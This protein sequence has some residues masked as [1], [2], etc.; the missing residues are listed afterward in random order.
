[1][2]KLNTLIAVLIFVSASTALAKT[3]THREVE[4]LSTRL[5]IFYFKVCKTFIGATIEIYDENGNQIMNEAINAQKSIVDFYNESAGH[6]TIV[7]KK[8]KQVE[9]FSYYKATPSPYADENIN[10][11]LIITSK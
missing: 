8:G 5:D 7:I 6:Y 9:E 10:H 3:Q 2:K 1:M 11:R 4:V